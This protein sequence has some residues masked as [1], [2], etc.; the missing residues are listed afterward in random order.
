MMIDARDSPL[1]T[2]AEVA[3]LL[4]ISSKRTGEI[5]RRALK[6]VRRAIE[7]E[8]ELAGLSVREWLF[9]ER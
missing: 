2:R 9:A 1:K 4:G 8:A 5:E 7:H 6:K 3:A